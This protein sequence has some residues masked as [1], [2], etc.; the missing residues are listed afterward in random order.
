MRVLTIIHGFPPLRGGAEIAAYSVAKE[1]VSLG[2]Q[3]AVVTSNL[4]R[5]SEFER[6]DGVDVYRV[7]SRKRLMRAFTPGELVSFYRQARKALADIVLKFQPDVV[8]AHF[9]IPGG[10]LAWGQWR[11]RGLPYVITSHGS[12]VPGFHQ[13]KYARLYDLLTPVFR[14]VAC[15]ASRMVCVSEQLKIRASKVAPDSRTA[16]LYNGVDHTLF[17][18]QLRSY[19]ERPGHATLLFVGRLMPLK[20][21][22]FLLEA[23]PRLIREM[24]GVDVR[25]T[26]VGNGEEEVSL[27][28]LAEKMG[29]GSSVDFKGFLSQQRLAEEYRKSDVFILPSFGDAAPLA[30]VEA[31]A[32]G[33]PVVASGVGG[34]P[35]L[36][37]DS[38]QLVP[39]GDADRLASK[40]VKFLTDHRLRRE[41]SDRN[42]ERSKEFHWPKIGRKYLALL[43]QAHKQ[44]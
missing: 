25:L 26:M 1:L 2:A 36:L 3:V 11:D 19:P 23:M 17:H 15:N 7:A 9:A 38:G 8:H 28:R 27:R 30:L 42:L 37:S 33:L 44:G 6:V 29:I 32:S 14:K 31:M 39:P 16:I 41:I 10:L 35:E 34:I 5:F 13:K 24:R 18:P 20:G 12:D 21:A 22:R 43:Q 40:V 4:Q